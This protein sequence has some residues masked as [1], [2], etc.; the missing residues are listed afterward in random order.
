V[1][2]IDYIDPF[3][4]LEGWPHDLGKGVF[5][6]V[7]NHRSR[8]GGT[9]MKLQPRSQLYD[10]RQ[11][12]ITGTPRLREPRTWA[13]VVLEI[14]EAFEREKIDDLIQPGLRAR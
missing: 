4:I 13:S 12:A 5:E 11:T 2:V 6:D 3:D 14:D 9:I 1:G 10:Q 7:H 8:D